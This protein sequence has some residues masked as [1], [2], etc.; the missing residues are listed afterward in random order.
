MAAP[1]ASISRAAMPKSATYPLPSSSN[2]HVGRLQIAMDHAP[3]VG[4]VERRAD[5]T[6]K[7]QGGL[8]VPRP[9]IQRIAQAPTT[10]PAGHQIC[11]IGLAP[12]VVERHDVG[13]LQL[14]D[15]VGLGLE[16]AD[17][18]RLVDVLGPDHL[19]RHL[20]TNRRLVGAV[21]DPEV[22]GTRPVPA[23]RSPGPPG[24]DPTP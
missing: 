12:E 20:A 15:D 16:A 3:P 6:E 1:A 22:A 24:P 7:A 13:V 18:L 9:S 17:E 14:G 10:Q 23:T 11:A 19:D 8:D 5:L 21:H 4:M 2:E